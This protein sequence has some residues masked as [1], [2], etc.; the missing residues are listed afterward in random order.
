ML[1]TYVLLSFD[2]SY[3]KNSVYPDLSASGETNWWVKQND[4]STLQT[5]ATTLK[6][7]RK[8]LWK[9]ILFYS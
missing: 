4:A 6:R 2:I 8:H 9:A 3:F 5:S 1:L 7:Y